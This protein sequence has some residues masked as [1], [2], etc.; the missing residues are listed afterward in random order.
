MSSEQP[1]LRCPGCGQPQTW[2]RNNP[3]RPFCSKRCRDS[4]FVAWANEEHRIGGN[5]EYDDLLS[6]DLP[7]RHS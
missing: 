6:E 4:D 2:D 3:Y 1:R 5:S 7:P